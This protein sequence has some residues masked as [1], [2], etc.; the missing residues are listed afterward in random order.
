MT[1]R[2]KPFAPL[3][4]EERQQLRQAAEK[5]VEEGEHSPVHTI[6]MGWLT[7][8][9]MLDA[10]HDSLTTIRDGTD[11][12]WCWYHAQRG[13]GDGKDPSRDTP[14]HAKLSIANERDI[15]L[16]KAA[17]GGPLTD[18]VMAAIE[19]WLQ[20]AQDDPG[21]IRGGCMSPE[22]YDAMNLVNEYVQNDKKL[23]RSFHAQY[24]RALLS[25]VKR[26][27]EAVR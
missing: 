14:E 3:T 7:L 22:W 26:L 6:G 15:A 2:R 23:Q 20:I 13:L 4:V 1:A 9:D 8:L 19:S 21:Y 16:H 25:E 5:M 12:H 24:A 27:R 11:N 18:E 17:L 10:A